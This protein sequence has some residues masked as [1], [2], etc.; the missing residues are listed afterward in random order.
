MSLLL[1]KRATGTYDPSDYS[2]SHIKQR[3]DY[4]NIIKA[5]DIAKNPSKYM[6]VL[7]F[8]YFNTLCDLQPKALYIHSLSEPFNEEMEISYE[9]MQ[10]WLN[11]FNI[12]FV[13]AHCSGHICGT[14]LKEITNQINPKKLYP[15]HTDH[16]EMFNAFHSGTEMV[17]EG[18]T[19]SI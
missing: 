18:K 12:R 1:P 15:I 9:R 11:H 10:N 3:L 14:D 16:P 2:D 17:T 8:W 19:Y 5:E 7:N 6:I 13:Q 4:P